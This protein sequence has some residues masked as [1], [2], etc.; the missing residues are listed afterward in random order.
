MHHTFP[1]G[2]ALRQQPFLSQARAP[3][4]GGGWWRESGLDDLVVDGAG[5]CFLFD[6]VV[7][8]GEL[9]SDGDIAGV[10]RKSAMQRFE[11]LQPARPAIVTKRNQRPGK[12]QVAIRCATAKSYQGGAC[13][14][15]PAAQL[16]NGIVRVSSVLNIANFRARHVACGATA[17]PVRSVASKT[18][19]A[20][21]LGLNRRCRHGMRI[22]S[23]AA[24]QLI[25]RLQIAT[26]AA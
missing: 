12:R 4:V 11:G 3:V 17:L 18:A 6:A 9:G 15:G 24:P 10:L 14:R 26:A 1:N 8:L 22:V 7:Q 20:V 23:C 25:A 2:N 21:E 13:L 5:S 19:L 16:G